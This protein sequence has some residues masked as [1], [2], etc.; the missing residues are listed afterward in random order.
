MQML[1]MPMP[2]RISPPPGTRSAAVL[3]IGDSMV[4]RAGFMTHPPYYITVAARGGL[5][6]RRDLDWIRRRTQEWT[7]TA[8]AEG[9]R[10]GPVL[11]WAGGNDVYPDPRDGRRGT[12]DIAR[13]GAL[14]SELTTE[15]S[16]IT[17]IGPTP[18][19]AHDENLPWNLTPAF[20]LERQMLALRNSDRGV[21]V[22]SVG[23][24][25]CQWRNG[26][27]RGYFVYATALFARDGVHLSSAGYARLGARLPSW[28]DVGGRK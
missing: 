21:A 22:L 25:L 23:R 12:P 18:R 27:D 14:L 26:R 24:R 2:M 6:W 7:K 16:D 11:I 15:I 8:R 5:S 28:L 20:F 9:R 17:L 3:I 19:P 10:L 4:R 1:P 13:V